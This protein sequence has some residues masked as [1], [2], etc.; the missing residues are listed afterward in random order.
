[1]KRGRDEVLIAKQKIHNIINYHKILVDKR[2]KGCNLHFLL[3]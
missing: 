2:V 3:V 1:M